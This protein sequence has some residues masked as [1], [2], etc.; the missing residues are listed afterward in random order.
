MLHNIFAQHLPS[1]WVWVTCSCRDEL[2]PEGFLEGGSSLPMLPISGTL[3]VCTMNGQ[4][5]WDDTGHVPVILY[6]LF[7]TAEY[8]STRQLIFQCRYECQLVF[9]CICHVRNAITT[10]HTQ[11][12]TLLSACP[13][14]LHKLAL[15][16]CISPLPVVNLMDPD[17]KLEGLA[18]CKVKLLLFLM[19]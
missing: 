19:Y 8:L 16:M 2:L 15:C 4:L 5:I 1:L 11:T 10:M 17:N 9:V 14:R 3:S 13:G 12:A 7:V 18:E 6:E